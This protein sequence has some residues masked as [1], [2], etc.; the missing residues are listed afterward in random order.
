M[1]MILIYYVKRISK[2]SGISDKDVR[3]DGV[4]GN[5]KPALKW[6]VFYFAC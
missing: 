5:K 2:I 4:S 1:I 3:M 6:R